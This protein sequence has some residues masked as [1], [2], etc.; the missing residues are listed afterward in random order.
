MEV[1]EL[2][3]LHRMFPRPGSGVPVAL[4]RPWKLCHGLP[5]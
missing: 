4:T 1:L 5:A 2:H 3:D